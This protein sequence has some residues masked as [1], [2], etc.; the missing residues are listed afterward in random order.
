VDELLSS[1]AT[2]L[3][4][5]RIVG[6]FL[7]KIMAMTDRRTVKN[8]SREKLG[9]RRDT[10]SSPLPWILRTI[11]VDDVG[12]LGVLATIL[13]VEGFSVRRPDTRTVD[14]VALAFVE[15]KSDARAANADLTRVSLSISKFVAAVPPPSTLTGPSSGGVDILHELVAVELWTSSSAEIRIETALAELGKGHGEIHSL[16]MGFSHRLAETGLH[17]VLRREGLSIRKHPH[18]II[19]A[20]VLSVEELLDVS[21]VGLEKLLD[22]LSG[23]TKDVSAFLADGDGNLLVEG[24]EVEDGIDDTAAAPGNIECLRMDITEMARNHTGIAATNTEGLVAGSLVVD[25]VDLFT[26]VP[27][28]KRVQI[29]EHL[30]DSEVLE[31]RSGE[32]GEGHGFAKVAVLKS[33]DNGVVLLCDDTDFIVDT[34]GMFL[35]SFTSNVQ[36]DRTIR[37]LPMILNFIETLLESTRASSGFV[38]D[39]L[40]IILRFY[41]TTS[42]CKT[43]HACAIEARANSRMV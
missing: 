14:S 13:L 19:I 42:P 37:S 15:V 12:G 20:H 25:S 5:F 22:A 31:I 43:I 21:V 36:N 11:E 10:D 8:V 17:T 24:G 28:D 18:E 26:L 39:H 4:V 40:R 30:S 32:V 38:V 35:R 6:S 9:V 2:T 34:S 29:L 3:N 23:L 16:L 33:E 7:A 1:L 27:G 41:S